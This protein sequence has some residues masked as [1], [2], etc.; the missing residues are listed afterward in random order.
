[1]ARTHRILDSPA[2]GP[3]GRP[4]NIAR[5]YHTMKFLYAMAERQKTV[6]ASMPRVLEFT[7]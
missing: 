5:Q 3:Q 4:A 1:M 7:V 2:D 6:T